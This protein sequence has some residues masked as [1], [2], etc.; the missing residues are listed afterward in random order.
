MQ[1]IH[2]SEVFEVYETLENFQRE[3]QKSMKATNSFEA[4]I[5]HVWYVLSTLNGSQDQHGNQ[6]TISSHF[7]AYITKLKFALIDINL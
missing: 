7:L 6:Q 2:S 1:N 3:I 5:C 4:K